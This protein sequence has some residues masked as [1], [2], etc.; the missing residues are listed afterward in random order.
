MK[1]IMEFLSGAGDLTADRERFMRAW[2][3]NYVVLGIDAHAK[4]YS[5]LIQHGGRFRLA[6]LYD[7]ISALPYDHEEF[8]LLAMKVGGEGKWRSIG[9]Y[10]WEKEAKICGYICPRRLLRI[11]KSVSARRC[12]QQRDQSSKTQEPPSW[13]VYGVLVKLV[14]ELEKRCAKLYRSYAATA[15]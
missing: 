6:P 11:L 10:H 13:N 15:A 9:R 8:N 4:N 3:F 14:E 12:Q 7:M 2:I 5:V 1:Q